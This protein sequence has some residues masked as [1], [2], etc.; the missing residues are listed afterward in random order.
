[1]YKNPFNF[2]ETQTVP[3]DIKFSQALASFCEF[4]K[5]LTRISVIA[6]AI[7]YRLFQDGI[8]PEML[9]FYIKTP[10]LNLFQCAKNFLYMCVN[11]R[12]FI[13]N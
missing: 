5:S 7:F 11:L 13:T 4:N 9:K 6:T 8:V 2:D 12:K 1:M 10:I 3:P